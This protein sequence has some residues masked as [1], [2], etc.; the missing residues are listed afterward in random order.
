MIKQMRGGGSA[1]SSDGFSV[2]VYAEGGAY[3][4][5]LGHRQAKDATSLLL[6]GRDAKSEILCVLSPCMFPITDG[7]DHDRHWQQ[8]IKKMQ[9]DYHQAMERYNAR[10]Q[11]FA[12][13]KKTLNEIAVCVTFSQLKRY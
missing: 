8:E 12:Q 4:V 10:K 3:S 6:T 7:V 5:P 9:V 2:R 1:W 13:G 11:D